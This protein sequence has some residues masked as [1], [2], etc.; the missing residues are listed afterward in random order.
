MTDRQNDRQIVGEHK[1]VTYQVTWKVEKNSR[2]FNR[3]ARVFLEY[4]ATGN[5]EV[6]EQALREAGSIGNRV[7]F[8]RMNEM[9]NNERIASGQ[10]VLMDIETGDN[11]L[12]G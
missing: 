2:S 3:E 1:G 12:G 10:P 7:A 9:E 6:D 8:S 4:P 5:Q 11:I